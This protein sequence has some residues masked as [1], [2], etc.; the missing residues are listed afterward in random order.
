MHSCVLLPSLKTEHART[1]T[2]IIITDFKS[3]VVYYLSIFADIVKK[4][5]SRDVLHHHK[6]ISGGANNLIPAD[7][8]TV[9]TLKSS[10]SSIIS[11]YDTAQIDSLE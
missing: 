10:G 11:R 5:A 7:I 8:D 6:D 3:I 2:D 4:L 9:H 1:D